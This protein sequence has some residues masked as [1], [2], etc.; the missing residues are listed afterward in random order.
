ML[1]QLLDGIS[2]LPILF[3]LGLLLSIKQW[4]EWLRRVRSA[5]WPIIP[6]AIEG[7]EVS[8]IRGRRGYTYRATETA[9]AKLG[10]SY[11]LEGAYYSGYHT[12]TFN[13]E[14]QAWS[15]V[16][17]LKGREVQV[18]YNPRKPQVSVLRR[19]QLN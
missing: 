2:V 15:Y 3:V 11:Q 9:T 7:G 14:Q 13:D 4:P 18:S 19:Q 8:T 6:G 10:Y 17:S 1:H 16:D 12:E 5:H